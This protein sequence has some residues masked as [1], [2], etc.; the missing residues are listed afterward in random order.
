MLFLLGLLIVGSCFAFTKL[1]RFGIECAPFFIVSSLILILYIFAYANLL[2]TGIHVEFALMAVT[3]CFAAV[4]LYRDRQQLFTRYLTPGFVLFLLFLLLLCGFALHSKLSMWDEFSHW[5]PHAASLYYTNAF[6]T[7]DANLGHMS[8]PPGAALFQY[9]FPYSSAEFSVAAVYVAQTILIFSPLVVLTRGVTW[10]QWP[11]AGAVLVIIYVLLSLMHATLGPVPSLYMETL[12]AVYWGSM[13]AFYYFS[14]KKITAI[15]YL[16]PISMTF[17]LFKIELLPFLVIAVSLIMLDQALRQDKRIWL[18]PILIVMGWLCFYTWHLYLNEIQVVITRAIAKSSVDIVRQFTH[19]NFND[20]QQLTIAHF[21]HKSVIQ[22]WLLLVYMIMSGALILKTKGAQRLTII[23]S[24]AFLLF[25]YFAF[26]FSLLI[27]YLYNFSVHEAIALASY[28]RY[29]NIFQCGWLLILMAQWLAWFYKKKHSVTKI[30]KIITVI[31]LLVLSIVMCFLF[32]AKSKKLSQ[33]DGT[34]YIQTQVEKIASAVK[35]KV[36][37]ENK[38][39][40]VWQNSSGLEYAILAYQMMPIK[41]Y[42]SSCN[43]FGRPYAKSD[44][45]SCDLSKKQFLAQ[46][47]KANFVLLAYTDK[48]FWKRYGAVFGKM[49]EPVASYYLC[50]PSFNK[51]QSKKQCANIVQHAYL[52][53]VQNTNNGVVLTGVSAGEKQ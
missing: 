36:G 51:S 47:A 24:N 35:K 40:I 39:F 34:W 22:S 8:Y 19:W 31:M 41:P 48:Q 6:P 45:Y 46:S 29:M 12:L 30:Q 26:L 50:D 23:F 11:V 18:T 5:A 38:V 43:S 10:Q 20:W 1:T 13:V 42:N 14:D 32:Y 9:L 7:A 17:M 2:E 4:V 49:P 52:Y 3:S 33:S 53:R 28:N 15:L 27:E 44:Y 16:L 37:K 25:A 21:I